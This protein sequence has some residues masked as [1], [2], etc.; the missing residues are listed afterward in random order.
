[1][2]PHPNLSTK[3]P[4]LHEK[5]TSL[6]TLSIHVLLGGRWPVNKLRIGLEIVCDLVLEE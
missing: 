6:N 4:R 3:H 2:L 1:V 5:K